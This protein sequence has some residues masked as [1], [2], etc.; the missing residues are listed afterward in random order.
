MPPKAKADA[1]AKA[2]GEPKKKQEKE[3]EEE[4]KL[5]Q[6]DRDAYQKKLTALQEEIDD[7]QKEKQKVNDQIGQRSTGKDEFFTQKE[8]IRAQ[9]NQIND[10]L[11]AHDA[12]KE[13]STPTW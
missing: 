9:L 2:K 7:L 1:K 5:K 4:N 13:Q 11:D 6:P 10:Q 3:E 12:K 8:A